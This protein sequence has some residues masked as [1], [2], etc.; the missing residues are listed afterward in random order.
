MHAP[1]PHGPI[2]SPRQLRWHA[3][4]FYGFLHF[5]VNTFTDREWGYG[6]ES[7]SV[8]NP[9]ALD[10]RQWAQTAKDAGMTGLILTAKH[11]DGFCLWPSRYTEHSIKNCPWKDGKGD[12]VREF[13]DACREYGLRMGLYLS[14]WD[15][16][17]A[18]YGTPEYV[19]YYHHQL[20]ELLTSYGEL[21]ELWFD[22]ANG[23]DGYYGGA[24]ETRKIDRRSYYRFPDIWETVRKHQPNAVMFSDAGPDIRWVGNEAGLAGQTCWGKIDPEGIFVGEVDDLSRLG[25]GDADGTVWRPAEA[26][27]SIR[28]GWF[29]HPH[30]EPHALQQLLGIYDFSVCRGSNLLLNL[31]PDRRGLI[32]EEDVARLR[33]FRQVLDER[34][35]NDV[36]AGKPASADHVRGHAPAFAA[37]NVTDGSPETYWAADDD[38]RQAEVIVDFSATPAVVS[39]VRVEEFLPLGQRIERFAIDIDMSGQWMEM[40]VGTTIGARRI[41]HFPRVWARRARLRILD[42]QAC[43]T[44]VRFSVYA[45]KE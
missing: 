35:A 34:Y 1:A 14:P 40:A 10:A 39:G 15:R 12:V 23:G 31:P 25:R 24:R 21:F 5:T 29:Y 26:D 36:A 22:G 30:E 13:H 27:V 6:D 17:H 11:H 38:V 28:P 44:I 20:E 33:E 9:N 43:P 19:T 4:E 45:D 3:M 8:F 18:G 16:N 32:P 42:A 41:I 2:P 7:P 37:G